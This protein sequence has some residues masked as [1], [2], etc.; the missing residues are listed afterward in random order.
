[1]ECDENSS[2]GYIKTSKMTGF[3]IAHSEQVNVSMH[4]GVI[5]LPLHGYIPLTE[6]NITTTIF[7]APSLFA[8][9]NSDPFLMKVALDLFRATSSCCSG[10]MVGL[11]ACYDPRHQPSCISEV[12]RRITSKM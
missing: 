1:M 8:V 2:L 3:K 10:T 7:H 11:S 9:C 4:D 5:S 12:G 6:G